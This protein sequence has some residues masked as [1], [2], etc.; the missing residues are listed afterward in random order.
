MQFF[1]FLVNYLLIEYIMGDIIK[2]NKKGGKKMK[3]K[4]LIGALLSASILLTSVQAAVFQ[5]VVTA[6]ETTVALSEYNGW[7]ESAYVTWS[8]YAGAE[9]YNVYVKPVNGEYTRLD[10]ML[11]REYDTYFRADALGLAAG[12][13]ILKVVPVV[14]GAE[15]ASAAAETSVLKVDNYLREGFAFSDAS[16]NKYTTGAYEKDGTLKSDAIVVYLTDANRD[17]LTVQGHNELGTGINNIMS[18]AKNLKVP[19]D[20]RVLG[21]VRR[22]DGINVDSTMRVQDVKNITI[23]GVGQDATLYGWGLTLRRT[24]N[25]EI[26]NAAIMWHC[27]GSDGDAISM[28]TDNK[29][30]FVH[31]MDFYYGAPGEEADQ[32][33][34]DGTVDM[35]HQTDYVTISYNHFYDTGKSSFSGGEWELSNRTDPTAKV[36]VTYHHNWFDHSD[37]RHPRCVVGNT[38]VYNN[39]YSGNGYGAAA[40]VDASVFVE[41]NYFENCSMPMMIGSQGSDAYRS[42]GTYSGSKNLSGQDGGMIKEYGNLITGQDTYFTQKNF[43][44][45]GQIDAYSV[46]D[47]KEKVPETVKALKGGW[48]YNNFDT[49]DTMYSYTPDNAE[50]AKANVMAGAGRMNGGDLRWEFSSSDNKNGNIIAGLQSAIQNYNSSLAKAGGKGVE[51]KP[52]A[53][54]EKPSEGTTAELKDGGTLKDDYIWDMSAIS[55]TPING[56]WTGEKFS[57]KSGK[58]KYNSE[59]G[60]YYE[61][62]GYTTSDNSPK[63]ANGGSPKG[64]TDIPATGCFVAL[65]APDN[66]TVTAAFR[67]GENKMSYVSGEG[68]TLKS[69]DNLG[70]VGNRFDVVRFP[71]KKGETYYIYTNGSKM[72]YAY[73]GF[74]AGISSETTTEPDKETSTEPPTLAVPD[75]YGDADSNGNVEIG[76]VPTLLELAMNG[77]G[78]MA[79]EFRTMVDLN[80]DGDVDS[81]D[82]AILLQKLLNSQYQM[83]V[84]KNN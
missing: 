35:K 78:N 13:Y 53:E 61:I 84:E 56:L 20:V 42:A 66:G 24:L 55:T 10:D 72:R 25:I 77:I 38:H 69:V 22:P 36:N 7:H 81:A 54:I 65:I 21:R 45:E 5:P 37:S 6:A 8:A 34:G 71:V 17:N 67:T 73:I 52:P 64:G 9:S 83:P 48:A 43:E 79:D 18:N 57:Y 75:K 59:D 63:T 46:N 70:K 82:V 74:T 26:R 41:S 49:A 80:A 16:P 68:I 31:N 28:D 76:D 60:Y 44:V 30:I 62:D 15:S 47:P 23:E 32:K 50:A 58:N 11:V 39:Y 12:N 40:C 3:F 4:K 27:N 33:K 2:S 14:S 19:L 51:G 29:N 1:V